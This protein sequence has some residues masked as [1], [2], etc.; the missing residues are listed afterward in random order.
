MVSVTNHIGMLY[1]QHV[2]NI[3]KIYVTITPRIHWVGL[4]TGTLKDR[5]EVNKREV[6]ECKLRFT[7]KAEALAMMFP[8]LDL[9][10][11]EKL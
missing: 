10:I 9:S 8:T 1:T 4:G 5:D 6:C 2:E 3:R 11:E 7:R